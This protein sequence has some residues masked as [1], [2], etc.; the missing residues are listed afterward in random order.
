M[1]EGTHVTSTE[2]NNYTVDELVHRILSGEKDRYADIIQ[3]YQD[4]VLKIVQALLYS[5]SEVEDFAHEI[6][7]RVYAKLHT[8]Q[9]GRDFRL[10]IKTLAR[11]SVRN[12][13]RKRSVRKRYMELYKEHLLARYDDENAEDDWQNQR[14]DALRLCLEKVNEKTRK[15]FKLKY[16][17]QE[18]VQDIAQRMEMSF[19]SIEKRLYKGRLQLRE[20]ILKN[21]GMNL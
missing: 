7:I 1:K 17:D 12:E 16:E 20:C 10:W 11:N 4:D 14:S 13:L 15:I 19:S 5:H 6:F 21:I 9:S 2:T 3:L 8:Y 18:M